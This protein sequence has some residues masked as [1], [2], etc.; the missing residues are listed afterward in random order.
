MNW[1]LSSNPAAPPSIDE[2]RQG[3]GAGREH[4]DSCR[5][6]KQAPNRDNVSLGQPRYVA[7]KALDQ[8][9]TQPPWHERVKHARWADRFHEIPSSEVRPGG[10]HRGPLVHRQR[11][12]SGIVVL[13]MP[14]VGDPLLR[15]AVSPNALVREIQ[16]AAGVGRERR[17]PRVT[18]IRLER[19]PLLTGRIAMRTR[20]AFPGAST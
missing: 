9:C 1:L 13:E 16:V 8:R 7:G 3:A 18:E 15:S 19:P 5:A 20:R 17:H 14:A 2:P 4:T 10:P 11:P 6:W 12:A